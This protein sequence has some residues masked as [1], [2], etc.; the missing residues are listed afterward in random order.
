MKCKLERG[1]IV[2]LAGML[3]L[4]AIWILRLNYLLVTQ[5]VESAL[6]Q[7]HMMYALRDLEFSEDAKRMFHVLTLGSL[8]RL[9]LACDEREE[10]VA[11]KLTDD[12]CRKEVSWAMRTVVT[13]DVLFSLGICPDLN[14]RKFKFLKLQKLAEWSLSGK[15]ECKCCPED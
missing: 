15:G 7:L 1:I 12:Q 10:I 5:R 2:T 4:F 14:H 13:N 6:L 8:D 11:R 9:E 3:V